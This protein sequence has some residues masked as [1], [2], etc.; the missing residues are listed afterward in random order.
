VGGRGVA[1]VQLLWI[2]EGAGR[3]GS[4]AAVNMEAA[5]VA[6]EMARVAV[7]CCRLGFSE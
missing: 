1:Q 3:C 2:N 4:S 7:G 6:A 5:N